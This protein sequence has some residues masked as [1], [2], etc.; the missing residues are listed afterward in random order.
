VVLCWLA[1][2]V[3]RLGIALFSSPHILLRCPSS[4]AGYC[5]GWTSGP[6]CG[7]LGPKDVDSIGLLQC[8][9]RLG[10]RRGAEGFFV[11]SSG[12][13]L[14][15]QTEL[16]E[17]TIQDFLAGSFADDLAKGIQSAFQFQGDYFHG[18]MLF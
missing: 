10:P 18:H 2:P 3:K 13:P 14:L 12:S 8:R 7:L 6:P 11:C 17:D 4:V 9:P 15:P 1:M 16:A 5:G